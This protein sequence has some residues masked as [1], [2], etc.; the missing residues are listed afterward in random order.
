MVVMFHIDLATANGQPLRL[1]CS[2]LYSTFKFVGQALRIPVR[3]SPDGRWTVFAID[4][5]T[6][7]ATH[8]TEPNRKAPEYKFLKGVKLC[9]NMIVRGVYTSHSIFNPKVTH[10]VPPV[11]TL[12]RCR[13]RRPPPPPPP[14]QQ[15]RAPTS[16]RFRSPT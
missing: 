8:A 5:P 13:R 11:L 4:I 3:I 6:L 12:S 15:Q 16:R 2:S 10:R 14:P 1:S 7:L 9:S